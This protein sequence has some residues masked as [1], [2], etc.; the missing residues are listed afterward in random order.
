MHEQAK[1]YL[2]ESG[3]KKFK[4]SSA[5]KYRDDMLFTVSMQGVKNDWYVWCAIYPLALPNINAGMG[6]PPACWRFPPTP[7]LS[8]D[9]KDA[10]LQMIDHIENDVF[11][12]FNDIKSLAHLE[13]L[14]A[15]PENHKGV[16][17]AI[18]ARIF[19]LLA[20][21]EFDNGKMLLTK[22][23]DTF[24]NEPWP[25]REQTTARRYEKMKTPSEFEAALHEE[26]EINAKKHNIMRLWKAA[27][28]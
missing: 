8:S 18:Y 28:K 16:K 20:M 25:L 22:L 7:S 2:I 17:R 1:R 6:W 19:A 23:V 27:N 24:D 13:Q 3:F 9:D 15:G 14:L 11:Q 10:E 21:G 4:T 5:I 12:R 26:R